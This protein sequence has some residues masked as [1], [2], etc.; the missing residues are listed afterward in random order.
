MILGKIVKTVATKCHIYKLKC[1][2]FE[3]GWIYGSLLLRKGGRTEGMG[4][5][6]EKGWEGRK[7]RGK[8]C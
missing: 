3:F 1:A 4:N 6:G 5:G 7:E 8:E 2:I